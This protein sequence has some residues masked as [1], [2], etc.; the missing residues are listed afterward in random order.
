MKNL[1]RV[2]RGVRTSKEDIRRCNLLGLSSP[3]HGNLLAKTLHFLLVEGGRNQW[4]SHR[5]RR[6]CIYS[7]PPLHHLLGCRSC[8]GNNPSLGGRIIFQ[9]WVALV[10]IN[11]GCVDNCTP[12]ICFNACLCMRP[13]LKLN[14]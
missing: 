11:R 1:A 6:H 5:P 8:E 12:F 2:V 13:M 9:S 7:Y 4:R 14:K 3:S 10:C